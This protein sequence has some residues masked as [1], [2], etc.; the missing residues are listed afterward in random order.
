MTDGSPSRPVRT[1]FAPSPSGDLHVGNVR[2]AL[3][4]WA[5]ARHTGGSFIVR[6][7]DTDRSRVTDEAVAAVIRSLRWLG[8]DWDEGPEVG[9]DYGP[10]LQSERLAFYSEW[11][12]RFLAEGAAYHCYCTQEELDAEREAQRAKGLPPGYSGRCRDLEAGQVTAY[13]AEGRR[14]VV[15]FRMPRGTTVVHDTIRGEVVFDHANIPDFVIM[16]ANGYP[17]YNLAASVDDALMRITHIVRGDD[18][19][20]S[21]P[22]QIAILR[23]MGVPEEDLPVYTHCP[24]VLDPDGKPLSKRYGSSAISWYR[25]NG[26]LPEAVVNYLALLGWSPGRDRE[27]LTLTALAEIFDLSRVGAT[28]GRLDPKKLDAINGDKIRALDPEDLVRRIMPFLRTAGLVS[29]PPLPEQTHI[30]RAA[31]PLVQERL[32]HLDEAAEMLAF[33][34]VREDVFTVDPESAARVLVEDAKA[35]LEAADAALRNLSTWDRASIE[36]TLR[37]VLI[38][39]LGR[40][41]KHAFGPVRVAVTGRRVSPPLFES[42]ELLGRERTLTRIR[43]ALDQHVGA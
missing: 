14:P 18:L 24:Y 21:T 3:Y 43:H 16:R 2:T 17:L 7:E 36:Q 19:L 1:R 34:L 42:L 25:Q 20:A 27:D 15:R 41:P 10:Y 37:H 28:A 40:R 26:Y 38:D 4:A 31:A 32:S 30:V 13:Q 9:G 22:R 23:A 8:L 5:W 6:I 12:E 35:V 39:E 11:A 29:D 33:L